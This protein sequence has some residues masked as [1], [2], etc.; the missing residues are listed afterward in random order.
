MSEYVSSNGELPD[1]T[2]EPASVATQYVS[3]VTWDGS[4]IT[5]TATNIATGI[6]G[7]TITL[8]PAAPVDGVIASWGCGGSIPAQFRPGSCQAAAGAVTPEPTDP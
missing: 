4:K 8:T 5:A 7:E 6:D 1:S 2:W 3:G